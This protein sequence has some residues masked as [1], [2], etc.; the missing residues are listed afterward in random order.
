[1]TCSS[2]SD[3]RLTHWGERLQ[4]SVHK[5][6]RARLRSTNAATRPGAFAAQVPARCIVDRPR[7]FAV[8][9][10]VPGVVSALRSWTASAPARSPRGLPRCR[11]AREPAARVPGRQPSRGTRNTRPWPGPH[12]ARVP[13]HVRPR[14]GRRTSSPCR[15]MRRAAA[16][17]R[18]QHSGREGAWC[19]PRRSPSRSS[20]GHHFDTGDLG[21]KDRAEDRFEGLP[22][23]S[24]DGELRRRSTA[25]WPDPR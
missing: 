6:S 24:W 13:A 3:L 11:R 9:A 18:D 15:G 7:V 5:S 23:G 8:G 22:D 14:D 19:P 20:E 12:G 16:N 4:R 1:M 10:E 25:L 17:P 2:R 21:A